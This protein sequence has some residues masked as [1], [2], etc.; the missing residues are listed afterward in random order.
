[1]ISVIIPVFNR[2]EA[3]ARALQTVHA[4]RGV[5]RSDLEIILVDDAS[6]RPAKLLEADPRMKI[7]RLKHNVGPAGARN[8][9]IRASR[10]DFIAFLDSDDI[11]LAEKLARQTAALNQIEGD[12][13]EGPQ[14]LVCGFYY[15]HRTSRGLQAR[16]PRPAHCLSDFVSGCWYC[17]GSTLFV[18]R[19]TFEHIGYFDERLRR[20]EDLDWFIRFGQRGGRLHVLPFA[21][22]IIAPSHEASIE[23]LTTSINI[24]K[25]RFAPGGDLPLPPS[26]WRRLQAYLALERGATHLTH[27]WWLKGVLHVLVSFWHKP[28]MQ[29]SVEPFWEKNDEVPQDVRTMYLDM[30]LR[31][32]ASITPT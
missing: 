16:M 29:T 9:G 2:P 10:G 32:R 30:I 20:L 1:V 19:A 15:P 12:G 26:E 17:P 21:G 25:S 18:R 14:A 31:Q 11:W 8:A 5:S 3:V 22:A 24:I 23:T 4:Q 7:V 28:R 6:E 27:G 13:I